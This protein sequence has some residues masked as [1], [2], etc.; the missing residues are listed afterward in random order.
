MEIWTKTSK[1]EKIS[2]MVGA[3]LVFYFV[4]T[5]YIAIDRL[6]SSPLEIFDSIIIKPEIILPPDPPGN[7]P[8]S[9]EL[10]EKFYNELYEKIKTEVNDIKIITIMKKDKTGEVKSTQIF[11]PGHYEEKN[12]T[13]SLMNEISL[14]EIALQYA[15]GSNLAFAGWHGPCG[16][17]K[18]IYQ[19]TGPSIY[20]G[21]V[22]PGTCECVRK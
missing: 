7:A 1:K 11:F 21:H 2:F 9:K 16:N 8:L 5:N 20:A 12:E 17:L 13:V 6:K 22:I 4:A 14:G 18:Y 19:C 10:K 15:S 3:F